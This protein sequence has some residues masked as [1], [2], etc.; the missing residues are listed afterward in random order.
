MLRRV[1]K[2]VL[3]ITIL[4]FLGVF[5]LL[6]MLANTEQGR[7]KVAQLMTEALDREVAIGDLDVGLFYSSLTV[8][9]LQIANPPD[10]PEGTC[11]EARSLEMGTS[12]RRVLDG[13][14]QGKLTGRGLKV[15]VLRKGD[16]TNFDGFAGS[17]E[18]KE[19]ERD[20]TGKGP[21]L[22]LQLELEDSEL[23]IEDL[24]KGDRLAL[25]GVGL[26]MR[27]SNREGEQDFGLKIRIRSAGG[28][29]FKVRDIEV[30]ARQA[31]DW[32]DIEKIG[33][34]LP[35]QGRL[36]GGGRLQVRGG[37]GW[38]ARLNLKNVSIDGDMVPF[39]ASV[40]PFAAQ[41]RGTLDGVLNGH[42]KLEGKGL[43]WEAIRPTLLGDG[44]VTLSGLRLPAD[45]VLA[46][47]AEVSGRARGAVE[48]ND[49]G[50]KFAIRKGWLE[51]QRISASG[52]EVRYDLAGRVSLTGQ[53]DL[54]MDI[55][56]LV[57]HFGGGKTYAKVSQYTDSIPFRIG[58]TTSAPR[59]KGPK[60][61]DLAERL[62]EKGIE[63]GLDDLF[64]RVNKKSK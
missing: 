49:A 17:G 48:L 26:Q 61:E 11:I 21:D 56:P 4:L 41:G 28:D 23:T 58:G 42:F 31:G 29:V 62:L 37:D 14:I 54:T 46:L 57:K 36:D 63:K 25:D 6:P 9:N 24:D 64:D 18:K 47:L 22:D 12:I 53:L 45:S 16:A 10:F 15:H 33:A 39:V 60:T 20:P 34:A 43:T 51:F 35:G 8:G 7:A 44:G 38:D 50:A 59:L 2:W 27:L 32:L 5:V 3:G 1:V 52:K 55:M 19:R 30:D 40:Y 13:L